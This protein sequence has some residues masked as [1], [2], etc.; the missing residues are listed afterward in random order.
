MVCAWGACTENFQ[1]YNRRLQLHFALHVGLPPSPSFPD[2]TSPWHGVEPKPSVCGVV[3]VHDNLVARS[4]RS[5]KTLQ[6]VVIAH[7]AARA[8]LGSSFAR[9]NTQAHRVASSTLIC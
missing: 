4:P 7:N 1:G 2:P 9:S 6:A 5:M 8:L 3:V